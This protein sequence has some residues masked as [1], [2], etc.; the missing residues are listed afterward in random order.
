MQYKKLFL[1]ILVYQS[2]II[3]SSNSGQVPNNPQLPP[4]V[5]NLSGFNSNKSESW[6]QAH[7]ESTQNLS[8]TNTYNHTHTH[9]I[10]L[11]T[12]NLHVPLPLNLES[13]QNS[14]N[15][16]WDYKW[17]TAAG[18][19]SIAYLY[20]NFKIYLIN[21]LL[22][23]PKS[24]S[25]WKEEI[26]LTRL[27]TID[28]QELYK[29]LTID[30]YKK[31]F[32]ANDTTKE[33]ELIIKFLEDIKHEKSLLEFYQS[34]YKISYLPIFSAHKTL[35]AIT[36]YIARLNFIMDLYLEIHIQTKNS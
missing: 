22:E 31:Y 34:V 28:A 32:N 6:L 12:T 9:V 18:I 29:Q 25:L 8:N 11:D 20:L 26:P 10:K 14:Y 19:T 33:H 13:L 27:T 15:N 24:W 35:E 4:I 21:K 23:D 3:V 7:Q 30:I 1:S 16:F 17:Y 2:A 5:F 36:Q